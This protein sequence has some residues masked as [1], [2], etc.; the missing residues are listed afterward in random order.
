MLLQEDQ[1]A[2]K[3]SRIQFAP[4]ICTSVISTLRIFAR[5]ASGPIRVLCYVNGSQFRL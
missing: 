5:R 1:A 2:R 3:Q 4:L